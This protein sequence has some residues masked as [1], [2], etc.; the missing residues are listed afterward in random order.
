V[1]EICLVALIWEDGLQDEILVHEKRFEGIELE[2]TKQS[3]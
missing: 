2:I 3:L 1:N